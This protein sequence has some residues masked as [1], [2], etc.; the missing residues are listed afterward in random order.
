MTMAATQNTLIGLTVIDSIP[1]QNHAFIG[2]TFCLLEGS[3][4]ESVLRYL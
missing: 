2:D 3:H 4:Y 1:V